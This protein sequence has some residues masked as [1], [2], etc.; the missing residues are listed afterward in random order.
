MKR[1]VYLPSPTPTNHASLKFA[2]FLKQTP[3]PPIFISKLI[4]QTGLY[5]HLKGPWHP[6]NFFASL[7]IEA[8]QLFFYIY[9]SPKIPS[10][11]TNLWNLGGM[12]QFD[13]YNVIQ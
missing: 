11:L 9:T 10:V 7:Y 2:N 8:N 13:H 5:P 12:M 3:P 6:F 1:Q 4:P